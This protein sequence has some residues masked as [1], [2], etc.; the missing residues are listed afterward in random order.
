MA[1]AS[2]AGLSDLKSDLGT[3]LPFESEAGARPGAQPKAQHMTLPRPPK[4][5]LPPGRLTSSSFAM[6]MNQVATYMR[7]FHAFNSQ[8]VDHFRG[9][10]VRM[11]QMTQQATTK[12]V[13]GFI[14]MVNGIGGGTFGSSGV[15]GLGGVNLADTAS[16]S[17][18][19]ARGDGVAWICHG[20]TTARRITPV[21]RTGTSSGRRLQ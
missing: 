1:G 9:R 19:G 6:Y 20:A 18:M 8:M 11:E 12:A 4:Q 5:P 2:A 7:E 14:P 3:T 21:T 13:Q 15:G 10:Q 16:W 17:W